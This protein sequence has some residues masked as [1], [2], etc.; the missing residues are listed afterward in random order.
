MSIEVRAVQIWLNQKGAS[1]VV[2]GIGGPATRK[3][4]IETFRNTN[5]PAATRA[6]IVQI[7]ERLGGSV[8]QVNAVAEVESAGGGWDDKG[9]LKCLYERHIAYRAIKKVQQIAIGFLS[10][11]KAGGYTVD[12]DRNGVNDSWEKIAAAMC[13][14]GFKALEWAS[15]GK[16]QVMGYHWASLGYTSVQ[17]MVWKLSR[18]EAAHYD[19]LARYIENNRLVSAFRAIDGKP[20]N[21]RA[22]AKGYNGPAYAKGGYH[23][24]IAL[25]YK[26]Q[27]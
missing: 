16:F 18:D 26:R 8:R 19:S 17:D 21:C 23:I 9:L 3:A 11:G 2:D 6:D 22:F 5:A 15:W 12:A 7:A 27:G 25:A 4:I 1:L 13:I 10:L 14:H 24:K 20:E